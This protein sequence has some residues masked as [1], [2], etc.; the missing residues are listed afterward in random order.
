MADQN[1]RDL[2]N[3]DVQDND[4]QNND[5]KNAGQDVQK[6]SAQRSNDELDNLRDEEKIIP[7]PEQVERDRKESEKIYGD[8][9]DRKAS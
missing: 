9:K 4:V 1:V 8:Q 7:D 6:K 2:Q 5:V 3:Q